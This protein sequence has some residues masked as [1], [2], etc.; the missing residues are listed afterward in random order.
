MAHPLTRWFSVIDL[1]VWHIQGQQILVESYLFSLITSTVT[2]LG[3]ATIASCLDYY[4]T[5]VL[6]GLSALPTLFST[7]QPE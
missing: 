7:W 1:P 6:T 4:W 5:S 2:S 3:Q